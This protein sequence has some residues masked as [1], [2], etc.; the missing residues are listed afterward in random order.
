MSLMLC[1]VC[2]FS[3]AEDLS[4]EMNNFEL[5]LSSLLDLDV[6]TAA[7]DRY[8]AFLLHCYYTSAERN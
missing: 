5:E 7:N 8:V 2:V 4:V 3:D 6:T 1:I